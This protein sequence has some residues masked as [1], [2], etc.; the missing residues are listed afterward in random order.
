MDEG[1]AILNYINQY[2]TKCYM[3]MMYVDHAMTVVRAINF[4]MDLNIIFKIPLWILSTDIR[5]SKDRC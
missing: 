5:G 4:I 3:Y 2:S 1:V